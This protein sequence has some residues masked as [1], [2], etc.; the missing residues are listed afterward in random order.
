MV[1]DEPSA[2]CATGPPA[3]GTILTLIGSVCRVAQSTWD[4]G[5]RDLDGGEGGLLSFG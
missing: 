2:D 4:S 3:Y 1:W 5:G